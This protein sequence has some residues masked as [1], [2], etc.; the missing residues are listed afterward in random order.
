MIILAIDPGTTESAWL[1]YDT[2]TRLP[3]EWDKVPNAE[4]LRIIDL[5]MA[6]VMACEMVQ[7]FGMPVGAEVFRT[8]YWIGRFCERWESEPAE[9]ARLVFRK[10]VKQHLCNSDRA[11][12]PNVRQAIMD[13]YGSSK[14]ASIG[15]KATP[16]PLYG[17][18]GD[19][20]SALGVAI[21]A[22]ET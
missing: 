18:H 4:M 13:R 21:T 10:K 2:E 5:S 8:V 6:D 14:A 9:P 20:W 7:S 3:I 16:G 1:A 19:C 22:A 11:K 15:L 17:L 12:D